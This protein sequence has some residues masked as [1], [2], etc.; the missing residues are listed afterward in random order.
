MPSTSTALRAALAALATFASCAAPVPFTPLP[1]RLDYGFFADSTVAF[2]SRLDLP[3]SSEDTV[4][5]RQFIDRE[6]ELETRLRDSL[7]E[8]HRVVRAMV[9]YSLQLVTV[10]D[11]GTTDAE[12]VAA[13]AEYVRGIADRV[14]ESLEMNARDLQP[15]LEIVETRSNLQAAL[16]AAQ[17]ILAVAIREELLLADEAASELDLL[18]R[19]LDGRIDAEFADV[20]RYHDELEVERRVVLGALERIQAHFRGDE[21]AID[22]LRRSGALYDRGLLVDEVTTY[23][24]ITAAR[25][26]LTERLESLARVRTAIEPDWA[27]Y[28]EAHR[29]VDVLASRARREIDAYRI[30]LLMWLR[31]HQ[32]LAAGYATR[33]SGSTS[34]RSRRPSSSSGCG[35][36]TEGPAQPPSTSITTSRSPGSTT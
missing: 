2:L 31:G 18:A 29:E 3:T 22:E 21:D 33:P 30:T 35:R 11:A 12:Q 25:E 19:A 32:K 24:D 23:E 1:D 28:R 34:T 15:T 9:A 27:D 36:G 7:A 10:S 4:L 13:Y 5:A 14:A 17:P 26:H 20:I 8:G 6:G 16:L